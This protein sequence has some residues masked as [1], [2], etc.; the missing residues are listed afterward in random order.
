MKKSFFRF[1]YQPGKPIRDYGK[2]VLLDKN[3]NWGLV[4]GVEYI[5]ESPVVLELEKCIIIKSGSFLRVDDLLSDYQL[6]GGPYVHIENTEIN[7]SVR[8]VVKYREE[9]I[10]SETDH[11]NFTFGLTGGEEFYDLLPQ[12]AR[13]QVDYFRVY[14]VWIIGNQL[15][16]LSGS[17]D[18][19]AHRGFRLQSEIE[20]L[21]IETTG[22]GSA[23]SPKEITVA[24]LQ[25]RVYEHVFQDEFEPDE[26][27]KNREVIKRLEILSLEESG[28]PFSFRPVWKSPTMMVGKL[29]VNSE[30]IEG[31]VKRPGDG[32]G[33]YLDAVMYLGLMETPLSDL[34]E[35]DLIWLDGGGR[36]CWIY[37]F[38]SS[39]VTGELIS[40]SKEVPSDLHGWVKVV[41]VYDNGNGLV[42][43]LQDP[44]HHDDY[45]KLVEVSRVATAEENFDKNLAEARQYPAEVS[46]DVLLDNQETEIEITLEDLQGLKD[47]FKKN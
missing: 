39:N 20:S 28:L 31:L 30:E 23:E 29:T 45:I 17:S 1:T 2:I 15:V 40:K 7:F 27:E 3:R 13:Q 19:L 10:S 32:T 21:K 4:E 42:R 44:F 35:S 11:K 38:N 8:R 9:V 41:A 24:K 36:I 34:S 18:F 43:Y 16:V 22:S 6:T 47:H 12:E 33:S 37:E 26:P 46:K 5:I 14:M 25:T